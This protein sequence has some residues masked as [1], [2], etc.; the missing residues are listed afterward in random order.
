MDSARSTGERYDI[1]LFNQ[2]IR[3]LGE[4]VDYALAETDVRS[5]TDKS[6]KPNEGA[7][8][9]KCRHGACAGCRRIELGWLLCRK[10]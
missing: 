1:T 10:G 9:E 2:Q 5:L 4:C 6:V 7:N 8:G 3:N